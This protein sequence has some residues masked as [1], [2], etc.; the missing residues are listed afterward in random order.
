MG[1]DISF[2]T[3]TAPNYILAA[4]TYTMLGRFVLS[5]L[6]ADKPDVVIY[7]VFVQITDPV[8]KAVRFVTPAMVPLPL[9]LV[10][11]LF[12]LTAARVALFLVN[13][14]LGIGPTGIT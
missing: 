10:L 12:W 11:S 8:V 7:K 14:V 5:F 6:F 4:L 3:F 13:R 2:F 9:V 1:G